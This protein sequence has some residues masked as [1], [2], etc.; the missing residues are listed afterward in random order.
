MKRRRL[1]GVVGTTD[2]HSHLGNAA[3]MAAVL[4][5]RRPDF[6]VVDSGDFFEGTGYYR[7]SEGSL[8]TRFLR[9]L[10]DAVVPGNH[11]YQHYRTPDLGP[12][13]VCC[14]VVL[15]D[16]NPAWQSVQVHQVSG[17]TVAITGIISPAAWACV[18]AEER[19]GHHV[20]DPGKA[21]RKLIASTRADE[22]VILSHSGFEHDLA[23]AEGL[24]E[25]AG[26]VF[27]GHCHSPQTGPIRA[28][29]ALVLKGSEL[30]TGYAS[31]RLEQDGWRCL[32]GRILHDLHPDPR[33]PDDLINLVADIEAVRSGSRVLAPITPHYQE[34]V[35]E[36]RSL[37]HCLAQETHRRTGHAVLLNQTALRPSRVGLDLTE[38]DL[39]ELDPFDNV[40]VLA[41]LPEPLTPELLGRLVADV[42]HV[43]IAPRLPTH[44][45]NQVVT[46][47]YLA[48][49]HLHAQATTPIGLRL[50]DLLINEMTTHP[51][52]PR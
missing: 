40:F 29:S 31:A 22:W 38:W 7:A 36:R 46:T 39:A 43:E 34:R 52:D 3:A 17:R 24:P 5:A 45:P 26:V 1:I 14:N 51:G 8:E 6:L 20:I 32:N 33:W 49:T 41:D 35:P 50:R 4:F 25:L 15:S 48:T 19:R 42:D 47:K 13:V 18:P 28:G 37:A 21:L 27:A 30:G 16:N 11:G 44:P 12:L 23:L 9:L 2:V 10:Y